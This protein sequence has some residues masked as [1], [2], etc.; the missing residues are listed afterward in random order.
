MTA[1]PTWEEVRL[2]V[3]AEHP[4]HVSGST[5]GAAL[6]GLPGSGKSILAQLLHDAD[7]S[8]DVRFTSAF[9]G[10]KSR[11]AT[12]IERVFAAGDRSASLACQV[13][14]LVRRVRLCADAT[15]AS[16]IDEPLES[17]VA[18][19]RAMYEA[20]LLERDELATWLMAYD[21]LTA[22]LPRPDLI[23]YLSCE[24]SELANRVA[25]RGR[26]RDLSV[27]EEYL[28]ALERGLDAECAAAV[29]RGAS[30]YRIDSTHVSP[31]ELAVEVLR[32]RLNGTLENPR[33]ARGSN[34]SSSHR[35]G[36]GHLF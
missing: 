22:S 9:H 10:A 23:V 20:G 33:A 18:H 16:V 36:H 13:E 21:I 8:L 5:Y 15:Q 17:V 28:D 24:R 6:I 12:W 32:G 11:M 27:S 29:A 34:S 1:C 14:A 30:V 25:N 4:V 35:G 19:S 2:E 3:N 31:E 7:K 26:T